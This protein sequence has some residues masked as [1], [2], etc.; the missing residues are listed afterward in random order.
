MQK[1]SRRCF[2]SRSRDLIQA[3]LLTQVLGAC[4]E[5]IVEVEKTVEVPR[6][7]TR[8][9]KE[10]VRETV[11]VERT[12]GEPA[13]ITTP[14]APAIRRTET[15]VAAHKT[16]VQVVAD[17][18]SYGWTQL[19][20]Q[21]T[22][23][24]EEMFPHI[25]ITWRS[26]SDWQGYGQRIAAL[27][28]AD[29]L[30]DLI[31]APLGV[32]PIHWAQDRLVQPLDEL[33]SADGFEY[34]SIFSGA[35]DA[36]LY[37]GQY[38]A[39]PFICHSGE[40][41]LLYD[42]DL[43]RRARISEPALDWTL[44][45]LEEATQALTQRLANGRVERYGQAISCE[46]PG[47]Y[48]L[49]ALFDAHLFSED[50]SRAAVDSPN[51]IACLDWAR[52]QVLVRQT[53]PTP[54]QI[55][56]STLDM[57]LQGRVAM[58]RHSLRTLTQLSSQDGL[59]PVV[60]G[61][62]FPRHPATGNLATYISGMAYAITAKSRGPAEV[63]QWIKFMSSREMGVQMFL[64]GYAEPGCRM[65]SWKDPR[66]LRLLPLCS[67]IA[68]AMVVAKPARHPWN[69]RVMACMNVWND[70][71]RPLWRNELGPEKVSQEI[72]QS[73][74]RILR[75]PVADWVTLPGTSTASSLL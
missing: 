27:H 71:L 40:S 59:R 26:L 75:Q 57:F 30:G 44:D 12:P 39:L 66:V 34:R 22:P 7:V 3:A 36:C 15:A 49:L 16:R 67:A 63:F 60:Q 58:Y 45:Q 46:M 38:V 65:A 2:L 18:L 69:L 13:P 35:M 41:L 20:M 54:N 61:T 33:M 1:Q 48:P 5:R 43:F 29:Q 56:R 8:V 50:G 32:L 14:S 62:L 19:G 70:W 4:R 28:A 17:V 25:G 37:E 74:N 73:I 10:I 51:A 23:T 6:E 24:F 47:S 64:G 52:S 72:A 42:Q 11:I 55:E 9:V 68:D 53:A 21:M 31:E